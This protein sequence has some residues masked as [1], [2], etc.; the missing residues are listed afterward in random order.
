[1]GGSAGYDGFLTIYK[2]YVWP[3]TITSSEPSCTIQQYY[4][5]IKTTKLPYAKYID[6][7]KEEEQDTEQ[8]ET[9]KSKW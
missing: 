2:A 7:F 8:K 9:E 5:N 3:N 4:Y 1:M 6:N